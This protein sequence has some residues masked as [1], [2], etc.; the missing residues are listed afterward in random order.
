VPC[1]APNEDLHFTT[2][3]YPRQIYASLVQ[4]TI[5]VSFD[6]KMKSSSSSEDEGDLHQLTVNEHYAKAF[7]YRK[8]REELAKRTHCLAVANMRCLHLA[9]F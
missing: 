8:E 7:Q 5:V 6:W 3:V 2:E 9:D 1:R 4:L